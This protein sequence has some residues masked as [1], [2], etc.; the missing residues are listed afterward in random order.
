MSRVCEHSLYWILHFRQVQRIHPRALPTEV[1]K[2][3]YED[4]HSGN[5]FQWT[6]VQS[7][8]I[9]HYGLDDWLKSPHAL[10]YSHFLKKNTP[11]IRY[12]NQPRDDE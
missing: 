3:L 4:G 2:Y 8:M 11:P 6:K 7:T 9:D 1:S 10:G 12:S 5:S